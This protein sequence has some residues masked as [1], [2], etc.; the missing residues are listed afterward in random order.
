M[1]A[2]TGKIFKT[3]LKIVISL[4][5]LSFVF[6]KIEFNTVL[7]VYRDSKAFYL[8]LAVLAFVI[9]KWIAAFRLNKF[10]RKIE[11]QLNEIQNLKLYILGM[12]YNLF[13]PGGIG[14]D[15]YKIY[16]LNKKTGIKSRKIFW[17]VLVD[18]LNGVFALVCLAVILTYFISFKV[19]FHY[20][21]WLWISMPLGGIIFYF[22]VKKFSEY[23]VPV[24]GKTSVLSFLVQSF[25]V[26]CAFL[27]FLALGGEDSTT[28]YLFIFLLSSIVA[29]FPVSI[30]GIGLRELTFLYGAQFLG[31]SESISV[32]LSLMFY[33]ITAFVSFWGIYYSIRSDKMGL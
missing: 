3:V 10:F 19:D 25:Q 1:K 14:G 15:G 24:L 22:L 2:K 27:I 4:A 21:S 16:I 26:L 6:S 7:Q 29:M 23:L 13:L 18:R 32:A 17:S 28:E 8:F 20:K 30:G 9:S 5:A 11:I 12:F 31:L 33:L